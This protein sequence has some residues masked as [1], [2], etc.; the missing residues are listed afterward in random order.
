MA[1][2]LTTQDI[3]WFLDLYDRQQLNLE[4]PYQRRSVW[5]PRDRRYFIDTILSNHPAPPVFLHKTLDDNGRPTYHVVDGKQRLQTIIMFRDGKV[6]VPEDFPDPNLRKKRWKDFDRN[7]REAFWNY[8]LIVEMLPD[9]SEAAIRNTFDRINRNA[10]KLTPQEMR[11]AKYDGWF[12]GTVEAEADKAE[13]KDIGLVTAA[14]SKR[15][16]DVQFLSELFAVVI[17]RE[18]SGFDQDKIDDLYAEY[19]DIAENELF[20]EDN[21]ISDIN[22]AK[23][24][25]RKILQKDVQAKEFLKVQG[26]LYSLWSLLIIEKDLVSQ[27]NDFAK[28]YLDFMKACTGNLS[29]V[30]KQDIEA[31]G[32]IYQQAVTNYA[33]Y[34]RGASTDSMPRL[35]RHDALRVGVLGLEAS[36]RENS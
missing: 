28:K 36:P 32:Y 5:S 14:R 15:M 9:A 4:P 19:D 18:I 23:D 16:A 17:N 33:A 27:D 20:V 29:N 2:S 7:A 12:I 11:H 6:A 26:N 21:F 22:F 24:E 30:S 10:R 3:T 25:I 1:R 35:R 8:V 31:A 13:W 34:I